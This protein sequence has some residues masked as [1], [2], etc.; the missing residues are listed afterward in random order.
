MGGEHWLVTGAAGM[1][2]RE[3]LAVLAEDPTARVTGATRAVLDITDSRAVR[4]RVAE[5]DIVVNT[6]A[7]TAVDLAET[8]E[9]EALAVNGAAVG[10]LAAACAAAAVPLIHVSTDHVF[11]GRSAFP[12]PEYAA[13]GPLNAYGR[14]K[15]AG[16][17]AVARVLPDTGYVVR[18]CWLYG[19]HGTNFVRKIL[20]RLAAE[21][22]V[23]VVDD[24][25]GQPTSARALAVRLVELGRRAL[26]RRAAA[27][28]YH[29]SAA[30]QTT[31]FGFARALLARLGIDPARVRPCATADFPTPAVRPPYAVLGQDRWALTGL[32]PLAHWQDMLRDTLPPGPDEG[33]E[34][35]FTRLVRSARR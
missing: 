19:R 29:G 2:A 20:H 33:P 3:V 10:D 24:Q 11:A 28:I 8:H 27:G 35:A 16:E 14:S 22:T 26:C 15:L 34:T 4:S 13:T 25:Y 17:R 7:W 31:W 5:H 23:H 1:L 21:E 9:A 30:G 12:Y 6:A 32:A 18:T